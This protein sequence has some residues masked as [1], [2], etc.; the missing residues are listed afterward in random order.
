MKEYG[1]RMFGAITV[2]KNNWIGEFLREFRRHFIQDFKQNHVRTTVEVRK[3]SER[4][5]HV[6]CIL[7]K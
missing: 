4:S 5:L 1:L 7:Q 2:N 3:M 6:N